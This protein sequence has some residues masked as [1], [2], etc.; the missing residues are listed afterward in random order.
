MRLID[1]NGNPKG[2]VSIKKALDLSNESG[3]DLVEI[4]PNSNPPVCKI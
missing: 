3:Y 2:V 4:A 1:E